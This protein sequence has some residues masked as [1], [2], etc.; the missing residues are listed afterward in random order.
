MS[1]QA[2]KSISVMMSPE[3]EALVRKSA[4]DEGR[5]VSNFLEQLVR[6][7]YVLPAPAF[8]PKSSDIF[9]MVSRQVDIA[10]QI[11]RTV[12]AGPVARKHK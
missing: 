11:A 1:E 9:P 7:H 3:L 8:L 2:K 4:A 6:R 12:K 5:S 10:E